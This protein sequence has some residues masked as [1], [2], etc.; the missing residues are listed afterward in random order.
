MVE[1][2]CGSAADIK[3]PRP[4]AKPSRL[5]AKATGPNMSAMTAWDEDWDDDDEDDFDD[6]RTA[7]S[8]RTRSSSAAAC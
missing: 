3:S 4:D 8:I 5:P 7:T 6:W 2:S 1:T